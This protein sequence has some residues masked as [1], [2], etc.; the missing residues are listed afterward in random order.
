MGN[1]SEQKTTSSAF[2][3]SIKIP[4]CGPSSSGDRDAVLRRAIQVSLR[5]HTRTRSRHTRLF[6]PNFHKTSR[7][8]GFGVVTDNGSVETAASVQKLMRRTIL[9]FDRKCQ[10]QLAPNR[11]ATAQ[12]RLVILRR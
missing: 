8:V 9:P 5:D 2:L 7:L 6:V 4:P 10:P 11:Y 12:K 1:T 3:V